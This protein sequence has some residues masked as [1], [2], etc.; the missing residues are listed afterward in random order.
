MATVTAEPKG[1]SR[2]FDYFDVLVSTGIALFILKLWIFPQR[3]DT[4]NILT[5]CFIMVVE[6]IMVHSG[7]MMAF[8]RSFSR[9]LPLI[10]VPLY[11]LFIWC[12]YLAAGDA[13]VVW[14]YCF[15]VFCRLFGGF[16]NADAGAV[17]REEMTAHI[18]NCGRIAE[19]MT[20]NQTSAIA[21]AAKAMIAA[22]PEGYRGDE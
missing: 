3:G 8:A 9:F 5:L 4:G 18:L 6:F 19:H 22:L 11:G 13:G 1:V 16:F 12:F 17:T 10:F 14:L 2:F 15:A 7:A 21:D 20:N